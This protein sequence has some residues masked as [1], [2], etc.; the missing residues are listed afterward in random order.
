MPNPT[1]SKNTSTVIRCFGAS[2]Q[3]EHTLTLKDFHWPRL[4]H[5]WCPTQMELDLCT[6]KDGASFPHS[7]RYSTTY[8]GEL[9]AGGADIAESYHSL[10]QTPTV[11]RCFGCRI[12]LLP[13]TRYPTKSRS[14]VSPN[15]GQNPRSNPRSVR[16][17]EIRSKVLSSLGQNL[18]QLGDPADA[19]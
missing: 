1:T 8:V 10:H 6:I 2:P 3:L 7:L 16:R 5:A 12:P 11:F 13:R 17:A 19:G 4:E 9:S 15:L 18:G 14:K